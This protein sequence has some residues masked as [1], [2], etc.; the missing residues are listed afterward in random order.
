MRVRR[1]LPDF[2]RIRRLQVEHGITDYDL[3]IAAGYGGKDP[4]KHLLDAERKGYWKRGGV[5]K[6]KAAYGWTDLLLPEPTEALEEVRE[7]EPPQML[8]QIIS[9]ELKCRKVTYMSIEF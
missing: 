8:Q 1:E 3:A 9:G 6:L 7:A 2:D 5:A 4:V